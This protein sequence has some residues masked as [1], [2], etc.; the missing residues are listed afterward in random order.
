MHVKVDA[1]PPPLTPYVAALHYHE[2]NAGGQLERILPAGNIHLLVNLHADRVPPGLRGRTQPP[3][4]VWR[5][6][7]IFYNPRRGSL[8]T[9]GA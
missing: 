5:S 3:A 1:L 4:D 9:T 2:G 6:M 7:T 8:A